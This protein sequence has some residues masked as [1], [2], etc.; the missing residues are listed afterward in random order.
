[1][2]VGTLPKENKNLIIL[3]SRVINRNQ[4]EKSEGKVNENSVIQNI[5][6]MK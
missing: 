2:V 6:D 1:M 5:S 4:M 3:G